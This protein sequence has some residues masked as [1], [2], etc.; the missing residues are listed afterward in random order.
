LVPGRNKP[1]V[2]DGNIPWVTTPDILGLYLPAK[3]HALYLSEDEIKRSGGKIVPKGA[4]IMSCVGEL[5]R[6]AIA[7]S[8]IVLNQQ[9]HAFICPDDVIPEFLAYSLTMQTRYMHSIASQTTI[10]YLNKSNCESIPFFKPSLSRQK[11]IVSTLQFIDQI[12]DSFEKNPSLER[13]LNKINI[14][15]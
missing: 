14:A 8:E 15:E 6:V 9:L 7:T 13:L 5:G 10:P 2:F 1:K 12:I 3:Q 4:V 11:E